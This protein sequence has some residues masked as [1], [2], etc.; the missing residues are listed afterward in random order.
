MAFFG[1]PNTY[2]GVDLGTSTSK[3]VELVNRRRRIE[4]TTY[5]ESNMKNML[6]NPPNG[7]QD[8]ISRTVKGLQQMMERAGTVA[9]SAV[10]ALPGGVVFS[11]VVMMPTIPDAEMEKAV[12]FA[13]RDIVPADIDEMV[14]GWSKIGSQPHMATD[15][16]EAPAD[17]QEAKEKKPKQE[18]PTQVFITAAPKDVVA[19]YLAVFERMNITLAALEVETF[20]LIRSL[21]HTSDTPTLLVDIGAKA[22]TYHIIDKSTPQLSHTIDFGGYNLTYA[23]A[24]ASQATEGEAE[25]KKIQYGML[26]QQGDQARAA[27]QSA[28]SRQVEKAKDLLA[29]YEQKEHRRVAT[30]IL[31]GGGANLKGL[32]EYWAQTL[33]VQTTIGNPWKGLA[34]P[35]KLEG[36]LAEI[37]PRFGVAV[38]LALRSFA[39]VSS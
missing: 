13:A 10:A 15:K 3:I 38:G 21:I 22:T 16:P 4:L 20:P 12:Q 6:V 14:L 5:A 32:A 31:I 28:V 27:L 24:Q 17:A 2:I 7:D 39:H 30:C 11:T 36:V 26:L 37:G 8:A 19:R 29:L 34:Y 35:E 1:S 23:L 25:S 9:D 18:G 33:G